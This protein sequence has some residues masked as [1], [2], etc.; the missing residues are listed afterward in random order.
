MNAIRTGRGHAV[1]LRNG[2]PTLATVPVAARTSEWPR[3]VVDWHDLEPML[4]R[5]RPV[6]LPDAKGR[7]TSAT[8]RTPHPTA[9]G[10]VDVRFLSAVGEL[11]QVSD[12]DESLTAAALIDSIGLAPCGSIWMWCLFLYPRPLGVVRRRPQPAQVTP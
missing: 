8:L 7:Y 3:S 6:T 10:M 1:S 4:Q 2:I 11:L 12:K 9:P 5:A